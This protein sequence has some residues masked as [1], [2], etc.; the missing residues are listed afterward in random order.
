MTDT[1]KALDELAELLARGGT[2]GA[3]VRGEG[4]L[5]VGGV[6]ATVAYEPPGPRRITGVKF[7]GTNCVLSHDG[8]DFNTINTAASGYVAHVIAWKNNDAAEMNDM[9]VGLNVVII[10]PNKIYFNNRGA[11]LAYVT[12]F[13]DILDGEVF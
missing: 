8:L 6:N 10:P 11:A 3:R 13:W 2:G 5:I 7:R 12:L 4:L 9:W 1:E